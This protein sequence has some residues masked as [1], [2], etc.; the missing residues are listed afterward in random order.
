MGKLIRRRYK[1][2]TKGK[3]FGLITEEQKL[4]KKKPSVEVPDLLALHSIVVK[5]NKRATLEVLKHILIHK[6]RTIST[7]LDLWLNTPECGGEKLI[8]GDTKEGLYFQVGKE[9]CYNKGSSVDLFPTL[10]TPTWE[11][12]LPL[13][14][15]FPI[16]TALAKVMPRVLDLEVALGIQGLIFICDE[17]TLIAMVTDRHRLLWR[18]LSEPG[19]FPCPNDGDDDDKKREGS[20][21]LT[22][23]ATR[24]LLKLHS[25]LKLSKAETVPTCL[26]I[27][28]RKDKEGEERTVWIGWEVKNWDIQ[29]LTRTADALPPN[30]CRLMKY[31]HWEHF[32]R[33][34][35]K[36]FLALLKEIKPFCPEGLQINI[37]LDESTM[38]TYNPDTDI[39]KTL[40]IPIIEAEHPKTSYHPQHYSRLESGYFLMPMCRDTDPEGSKYMDPKWRRFN[41]KYLM[42]GIEAW[43]DKEV[44]LGVSDNEDIPLL[45]YPAIGK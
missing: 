7:N 45:I 26:R 28:E 41:I 11:T 21:V 8:W 3:G 43:E 17:D 2:T 4:R 16:T 40:Q 18:H 38:E 34:N 24:L 27:S 30:L 19:A 31:Y 10:P 9:F 42:D 15:P 39:L 13:K 22:G 37:C 33:F 23:D 44:L 20:L 6:G 1:S 32:Y 25:S 35:R 5:H 36:Q 14:Q 29:I 12:E